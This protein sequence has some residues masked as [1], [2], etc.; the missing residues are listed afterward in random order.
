MELSFI[1]FIITLISAT[2]GNVNVVYLKGVPRLNNSTYWDY[3]F[4]CNANGSTLQWVVNG[5][6]LAVF[7]MGGVPQILTN[8]VSNFDYTTTLLSS[9]PTAG[10]QSVFD[11]VI[12]VSLLGRSNLDVIC[13]NGGLSSSSTNNSESI[14]D[15]ES[16]TIDSVSLELLLT[17]PLVSGS[18]Y[19][20]SIFVSGVNNQFMNWQTYIDISTLRSSD[21]IGQGQQYLQQ[22]DTFV[23]QQGILIGRE[24]YQIVSVFFIT[25]ASNVIVEC[26]HN[27]NI[28]QFPRAPENMTNS[29]AMC[30]EPTTG[31]ST[32]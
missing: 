32:L 16:Q 19:N 2:S 12:I 1:L 14:M 24:P 6:G 31:K 18:I 28:L 21:T 11:S 3:Y 13:G 7:S 9:Q 26:G 27:Q 29:T 22:S 4:S 17:R 5:N 30:P 8:R 15:V 25:D 20:T 23:T 10:G